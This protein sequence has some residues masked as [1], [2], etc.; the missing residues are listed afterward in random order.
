MRVKSHA[1]PHIKRFADEAIAKPGKVD[2]LV[3]NA[4]AAWAT[5]TADHAIG[6]VKMLDNGRS[7]SRRTSPEARNCGDCRTSNPNLGDCPSHH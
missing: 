1:D 2:V 4:G 5:A 3:N 7:T 6:P